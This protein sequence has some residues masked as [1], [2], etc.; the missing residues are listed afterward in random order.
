MKKLLIVIVVLCNGFVEA[1]SVC[2]NMIVK[3]ETPV[4]VRCLESI[5]S[6]ID[7]WVIVDTGSTDGTQKLI[8]ECLKDIPGELHERPWVN[9]CHNRNEALAFAKGKADYILIIDAD[10]E[11]VFLEKFKRPHLDKD[12]YYIETNLS[13][14]KYKRVQLINS[15]IEWKWSGVVHEVIDAPGEKS[16]E[17]L[18]GVIN[19]ARP[20]GNRSKDPLK[21]QKDAAVLELAIEKEPNNSRYVFYL[22]Q[23]Y[24]DAE[25]LE[26]ALKNYEKR[27]KMGG[28]DEEIFWS[29]LQ[30]AILKESLKKDYQ[31]IIDSYMKAFEYRP[32]RVEPLYRLALYQRGLGNYSEAYQVASKGLV[33]QESNDALFVEKWIYDY[34]LLLEYSIAAYWTGRY[35]E[36]LLASKIIK[37]NSS[38]PFNFRECV[39]KNLIWINQKLCT[40]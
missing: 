23:S 20:E 40:N 3:D 38:L 8:K 33:L 15:K 9:F 2:L 6:M 21:Y 32:S 39:E 19:I 17:C 4:I 5:K 35:L 36:A 10:E 16:C 22:A 18:T 12:F 1:A 30:V 27:I 26:K 7:Y 14:T 25:E 24:R 34:G 31:E 11:L 28:W 37:M 29:L 13:G